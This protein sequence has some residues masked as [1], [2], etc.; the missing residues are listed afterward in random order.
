ME[1][2]RRD[3]VR[4]CT[5]T[6]AGIGVSGMFHPFVRDVL[7]E[8]LTGQRPPVFWVEGQ[9]C[10]GCTVSLLNNAH[11]GIA[12]VLLEIIAMHFHPTI[13]AAEGQLAFQSM[14]DKSKEFN[15]QY[16]LIVEG[17]IPLK[18]DGKYCVVGEV[19]H[20]EYTVAETTDILAR[21]AAAVVAA[22]TCSSY[23]GV[24]AARGQQT[25]AVSVSQFLKMRGIP[26]PVINVPGCPP[27]PDWMVGTLALLLDA[28]PERAT[29][30]QYREAVV[31]LNCLGKRSASTRTL[32]WGHLVDLYGVSPEQLVFRGLRWFWA[33]DEAGRP[34]I[35]LGAA[36]AR[37][38]LLSS[39]APDVWAA[40]VGSTVSRE[41]VET[42]MAGKFPD[43]FSPAT[44]KSVAQ[45]INATLT[46]AGHLSGRARKLREQA[47]P[48]AGSV[49]YALLLGY[50]SGARGPELFQT[51]FMKAQDV[52]VAVCI[53][54]AE[55]AARKGWIEF[56]R[57]A[58]VM[59]VAF[60][61]LIRP[62]EEAEIREQA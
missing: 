8:T 58:D 51:R 15:S 32:T 21:S 41:S 28:C 34:L 24:P 17:S 22:G 10:T 11:P 62:E 20:H 46:Q 36:L 3:F 19:D 56:K 2:T 33:R 27:H 9:G 6:V 52:P 13:M 1:L 59:E 38:G 48:T 54:L 60:P 23:G 39:I 40:P 57:V 44:L 37:D 14:L 55:E 12:K 53:D 25:Q 5:G 4:I 35:A 16:V 18:A 49:A 43:R 50:A 7:A 42:F 26:T 31:D 29:Q 45:N 47:R 61:R 30:G